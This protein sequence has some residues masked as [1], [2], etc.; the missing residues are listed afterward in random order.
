MIDS[1]SSDCAMPYVL[2]CQNVIIIRHARSAVFQT[3]F[4]LSKIDAT[5]VILGVIGVIRSR[6]VENP[7][8]Q[9]NL[10][11]IV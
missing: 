6:A 3:L 5:F 8:S 1:L 2:Y 9:I 7:H 10:S 11:G 4:V